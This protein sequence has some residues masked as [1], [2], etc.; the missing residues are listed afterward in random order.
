LLLESYN[1]LKSSQGDQNARTIEARTRLIK[2]Y[3]AWRKP[4]EAARYR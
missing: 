1:A 3:E 2:L 4:D